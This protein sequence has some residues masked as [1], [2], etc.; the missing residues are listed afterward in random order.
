MIRW[1]AGIR[2]EVLGNPTPIDEANLQLVLDDLAVLI[3]SVPIERIGAGAKDANFFVHYV[4]IEPYGGVIESWGAP[5]TSLATACATFYYWR[6]GG[7]IV[8]VRMLL[9][10]NAAAHGCGTEATTMADYA[11]SLTREEVT[12]AFGF[13]N[14]VTG[15]AVLAPEF[16]ILRSTGEGFDK[17]DYLAGNTPNLIDYAVEETVATR[18]DD[19]MVVRYVVVVNET[20]GGAAVEARSPRLTVLRLE[21]DDWLVVAHANFAQ[22]E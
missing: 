4:L 5:L 14:D 8:E 10:T 21:G 17:E 3:P 19:V 16:Q 12:Q 18:S 6:Q 7:E 13:P 20:I 11:V 15:G 9:P 1:K 22:I 2:V